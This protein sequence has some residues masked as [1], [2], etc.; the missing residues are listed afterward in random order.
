M[1]LY[2]VPPTRLRNFS[3]LLVFWIFSFEKCLFKSLHFFPKRILGFFPNLLCILD[4]ILLPVITN[5]FSHSITFLFTLVM[6]S[7]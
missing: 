6:V 3:C 7:F 2:G 1:I 5:T 4:I